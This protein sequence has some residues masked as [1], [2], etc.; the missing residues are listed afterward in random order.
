MNHWQNNALLLRTKHSFR[1]FVLF[2]F[3]VF[4]VRALGLWFMVKIYFFF[5]FIHFF[6]LG[7][8]TTDKV[9]T[10]QWCTYCSKSIQ[11]LY[12]KKYGIVN[13]ILLA[14]MC[15]VFVVIVNC[16]L[17]IVNTLTNQCVL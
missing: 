11:Q 5:S 9:R 6:I 2:R 3:S 12:N 7:V 4:N 15:F 8:F 10:I 17:C 13:I 16:E 14:F 1:V